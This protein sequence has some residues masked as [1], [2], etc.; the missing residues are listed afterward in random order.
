MVTGV[1]SAFHLR[2]HSRLKMP[3]RQRAGLPCSING[4][5]HMHSQ[6][7][8]HPRISLRRSSSNCKA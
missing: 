5:I 6:S 7:S 1:K 8:A 2:L 4:K 3:Q